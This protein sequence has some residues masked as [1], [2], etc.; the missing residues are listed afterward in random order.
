M[1]K[2]VKMVMVFFIDV[3]PKTKICKCKVKLNFKVGIFARKKMKVFM[4]NLYETY[5]ISL[6][7]ISF[8]SK[9]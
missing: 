1:Q 5:S 7:F 3:K 9:I 4:Q 6:C 2:Y 8:L